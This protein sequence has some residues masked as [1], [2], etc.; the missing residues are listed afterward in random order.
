M[1]KGRPLVPLTIAGSDPTGGAGLQADL[2]VFLR[3]GLSGASVVTAITAQSPTGV[4]SVRPL[5]ARQVKGQ[6]DAL[7]SDVRPAAVKV[8][9]L[10][11]GE[12]VRAVARALAPLARRNIPIVLDPVFAASDGTRLLPR[13]ELPTFVRLL[14]PLAT[15]VTPNLEEAAELAGMTEP[16]VRADAESAVMA[17]LKTGAQQVLITGGHM[18]SEE[19]TDVLGDKNQLTL[20]SL[21]RVPRR[22]RVHGTGCALTAAITALL[23]QDLPLEQAIG[24]AKEFITRAIAG[25]RHIG[26][27]SRQLDFLVTGGPAEGESGEDAAAD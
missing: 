5:P 19:S 18:A 24:G 16:A 12:N 25:A 20:Y 14:M 21:P 17:I 13:K 3:F 11:S 1:T 26:R 15:V 23:A 8:G 6:L 22:R 10:G 4:Q 9:M 2:K 7:L 27:G